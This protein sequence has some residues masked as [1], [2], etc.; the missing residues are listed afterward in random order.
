MEKYNLTDV[1]ILIPVRLDS[2]DRLE[3]LLSVINF[4]YRYCDINIYILHADKKHKSYLK[5]LLPEKCHYTFIEDYDPV[6]FR[7]HYINE[8]YKSSTEPIIAIWD[9]DVVVSPQ[10]IY[11]AAKNIRNKCCDVCFPYDGRFFNV[12]S[13]LKDLFQDAQ[14]DISFLEKNISKMRILYQN[15][16]YGGAFMISREAFEYSLG[17]DESFYGWGPEDWNRVEKWHVLNYKISRSGGPLFHLYHS[18]D[19]NGNYRSFIQRKNCQRVLN[20][21]RI[22]SP[23]ELSS[24]RKHEEIIK[25]NSDNGAW[26][27]TGFAGHEYDNGLAEALMEFCSEYAISSAKDFGCGP[28][29]YVADLNQMGVNCIGYDANPNLLIQSSSIPYAKGKCIVTDLSI[30][31]K[32]DHAEP[33][34]LVISIEVGEHIPSV[35]ENMFIDNVC[36]ASKKFVIMSWAQENQKGDG[37]VNCKS[38]DYIIQEFV[39]RNFK[40]SE[41]ISLNIRKKCEKWWLRN[42]V[43]CFI[44]V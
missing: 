8:L 30:P 19:L 36:G 27:H 20:T 22:M 37:H 18:R 13:I 1:G 11:Y 9:A 33:V 40:Y 34:D 10:Q 43:M 16:Q 7:T 41:A 3:N 14:Y 4:L 23:T 32:D 42:N 15:T 2:I 38:Q 17:E 44:R 5:D 35:S 6:F 24:I 25:I 12:D 31:M 28:G 21:T 26:L 39:K 29:W